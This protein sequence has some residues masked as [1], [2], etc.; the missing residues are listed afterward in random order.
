V[1]ELMAV[2]LCV[3]EF[4]WHDLDRIYEITQNTFPRDIE[5]IDGKIGGYTR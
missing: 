3:R 2:D 5:R 1:E 4:S